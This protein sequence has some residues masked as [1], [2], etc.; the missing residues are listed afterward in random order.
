VDERRGDLPL[1][2]ILK[3]KL[4][5][6]HESNVLIIFKKIVTIAYNFKFNYHI[7]SE[8]LS[9]DGSSNEV[10]EYPVHQLHT[11]EIRLPDRTFI[12]QATN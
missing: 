3:T 9:G 11:K 6:I 7:I 2:I 5:A 1:R 4:L 12:L 10:T 8:S